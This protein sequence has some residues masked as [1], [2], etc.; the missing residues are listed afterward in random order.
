MLGGETCIN[1]VGVQGY[2]LMGDGEVFDGLTMTLR[3]KEY[4]W[5]KVMKHCNF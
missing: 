3:F 1:Y 2:N 5:K 4:R